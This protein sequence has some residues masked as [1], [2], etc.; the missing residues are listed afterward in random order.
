MRRDLKKLRKR[1]RRVR[2]REEKF[3]HMILDGILDG[4]EGV[5]DLDAEAN[6]LP[7]ASEGR[8]DDG[9]GERSVGEE[10]RVDS[11]QRPGE[12]EAKDRE[13]S[14]SS[15]RP[16]ELSLGDSSRLK[17]EED[18]E[19]H[20][21]RKPSIA[22]EGDRMTAHDLRREGGRPRFR[23]PPDDGGE[24]GDGD[25]RSR[26]TPIEDAADAESLSVEEDPED[27]LVSSRPSSRQGS[28][29]QEDFPQVSEEA[30]PEDKPLDGPSSPLDTSDLTEDGQG[31]HLVS[32]SSGEAH[33]DDGGAAIE[34]VESQADLADDEDGS[35]DLENLDPLDGSRRSVISSL[36]G[37]VVEHCEQ[38]ACPLLP[39]NSTLT[40]PREAVDESHY[41]SEDGGPRDGRPGGPGLDESGVSGDRSAVR[42]SA[43]EEEEGE[44]SLPDLDRSITSIKPQ[45]FEAYARAR[46]SALDP[47]EAAG[48]F[49]PFSSGSPKG[50]EY[51][52]SFPRR[53]LAGEGTGEG[54]DGEGDGRRP[55][56]AGDDP[57]GDE[58]YDN[59][60]FRRRNSAP[61]AD[62]DAEDGGR[63]RAHPAANARRHNS[64]LVTDD[65]R[66][67]V[68]NAAAEPPGSLVDEIIGLK[69]KTAEQQSTIDDLLSRLRGSDAEREGIERRHRKEVSG[70]EHEKNA[71]QCQ[72]DMA[73]YHET[74]LNETLARQELT[75]SALREGRKRAE[76]DRDFLLL[77]L[78]SLRSMMSLTGSCT[79]STAALSKLMTV[80][81]SES[82]YHRPSTA[83]GGRGIFG[84]GIRGSL[85]RQQQRPSELSVDK[86]GR[87][88]GRGSMVSQRTTLSTRSTVTG[89]DAVEW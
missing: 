74:E 42:P 33:E 62:G 52:E 43:D 32:E 19:D 80:D 22:S 31:P 24:D 47:D 57:D 44:S 64:D 83:K 29:R 35:Y 20:E 63:R 6:D 13:G 1:E 3:G 71:L 7:P 68:A 15:R 50:V 4:G 49:L 53:P 41:D 78:G 10:E 65:E 25:G 84:G 60:K 2:E 23:E 61:G 56:S 82:D 87:E 14:A 75:M 18:E 8:A 21:E 69:L 30:D 55:P 38:A 85:F 28:S 26:R 39:R 70:L 54:D 17:S 58:D 79:A 11:S 73:R 66:A 5:V 89:G 40:P 59:P 86:G 12:G 37:S 81:E 46:L 72:L 77:E 16:R 48:A 27:Y 34:P 67:N 88:S 76:A 45:H 36:D 51:N 9:P